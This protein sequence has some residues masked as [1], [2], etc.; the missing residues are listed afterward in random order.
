MPL[1]QATMKPVGRLALGWFWILPGVVLVIVTLVV[2]WSLSQGGPRIVVSFKDGHGLK[3]GDAMR[4]RGVTV[5]EV[6][7]VEL[8]P[9]LK[10]VKVLIDLRPTAAGIAVENS[11]FWI[12]R[13]LANLTGVS[14]LET[15]VGAKAVAVSPGIGAAKI[16]FVGDEASVLEEEPGGLRI[17]VQDPRMGGLNPGTPLTYRGVRIGGVVS[18]VLA[19]DASAVEVD[20]HVLPAYKALVRTN[21]KFWNVSGFKVQ[22]GWGITLDAESAQTVLAGGMAMATE[23]KL[24]NT[25]SNYHRFSLDQKEPKGWQDWN[26][27]IPL[28]P[29]NL[30][31]G[32]ALP[33]LV[34]AVQKY[35]T[36]GLFGTS[37]AEP[38]GLLLPVDGRLLGPEDLLSMPKEAAPNSP[39]VLEFR[40]MFQPIPASKETGSLRWLKSTQ[41]LGESLPRDRLRL[42][43]KPE[44][45][46]LVT[47]STSD[48]PFV[49]KS[50]LKETETGWTIS[51]AAPLAGR[52]RET[53]HGAAVLSVDDDKVIGLLLAPEKGPKRIIPLTVDLLRH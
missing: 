29:L 47:D 7:S 40:G 5:G 34:R 14:G 50:Q 30:P 8:L 37:P 31:D 36:K 6:R 20:V 46:Y 21:S 35:K 18:S 4:H 49:S 23:D 3:A 1:P 39:V 15:V 11:H 41:P 43:S 13:P 26:P 24:G 51:K 33:R 52:P 38:R 45:C 9:D 10:G 16:E 25:V 28:I 17:V 2:W 53:W 27:S 32:T 12:I 44:N 22:F 42:P 19:S 48:H